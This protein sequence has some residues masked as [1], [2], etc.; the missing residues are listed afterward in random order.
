MNARSRCWPSAGASAAPSA[1]AAA[2]PTARHRP[3]RSRI[4]ACSCPPARH[5]RSSTAR[6]SSARA[7]GSRW[8]FSRTSGGE[9]VDFLKWDLENVLVSGMKADGLREEVTLNFTRVTVNYNPTGAGDPALRVSYDLTRDGV[10]AATVA[11][12]SGG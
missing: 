11:M 8:C 6:G 3:R 7:R 2:A 4:F 12:A 10:A 5:P 1:P 9:S